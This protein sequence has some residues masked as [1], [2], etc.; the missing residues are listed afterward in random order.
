M[1]FSAEASFTVSAVLA[2]IGVATIKNASNSRLR[3]I[4]FVPFLFAIQQFAEGIVWLYMNGTITDQNIGIGA[5]YAYLSFAWVLWPIYTSCAIFISE[6]IHW[7]KAICGAC[8][9]LATFVS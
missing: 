7:R 1:C 4:A 6:K 3:L 8:V 5:Q 9:A 2:A